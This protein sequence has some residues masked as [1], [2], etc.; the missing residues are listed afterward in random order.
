MNVKN[1]L[2]WFLFFTSSLPECIIYYN[3]SFIELR[4]SIYKTSYYHLTI[5][6]TKEYLKWKRLT[7][8]QYNL[9]YYKAPLIM[10]I[11]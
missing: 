7:V 11:S 2:L 6:I 3:K 1:I 10:K 5:K 8:K 4:V 9:F